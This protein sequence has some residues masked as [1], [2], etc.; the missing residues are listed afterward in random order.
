MVPEPIPIS[1]SAHRT[2]LELA[3]R[4][5]LSATELLDVA[6][7]VISQRFAAPVDSVPGVDPAGVWEAAAQADAGQLTPHAEVFARLRARP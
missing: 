1:P 6:V 5:G 3:V 4:T 2:L 7:K